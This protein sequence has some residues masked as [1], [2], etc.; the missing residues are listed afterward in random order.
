MARLAPPCLQ[1]HQPGARP[2][3][4]GGDTHLLPEAHRQH[5]PHLLCVFHHLR[6]PGG[7][8]EGHPGW[9]G[10]WVGSVGGEEA[11]PAAHVSRPC[12]RWSPVEQPGSLPAVS[13]IQGRETDWAQMAERK[14]GWV[15]G[16]TGVQSM[17][18]HRAGLG[19]E[20]RTAWRRW[21][22]H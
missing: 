14:A 4:G 16:I 12:A 6:H 11:H 20:G 3:A 1:C 15:N 19:S 10:T 18:E 9:A 8:G 5:C 7:A 22:L 2:E 13:S 21:P 17:Q